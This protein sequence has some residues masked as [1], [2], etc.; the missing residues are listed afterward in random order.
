L[1]SYTISWNKTIKLMLTG[2]HKSIETMALALDE[3][4]VQIMH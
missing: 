3:A 4:N 1:Q 2:E